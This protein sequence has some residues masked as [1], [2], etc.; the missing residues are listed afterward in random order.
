MADD[1]QQLMTARKI[2]DASIAAKTSLSIITIKHTSVGDAAYAM[3]HA[4]AD[5]CTQTAVS[6]WLQ[7][8]ARVTACSSNSFYS[9]TAAVVQP[10]ECE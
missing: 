8:V 1:Q 7:G 9:P 6:G 5:A 10:A 4:A 3:S 2:T